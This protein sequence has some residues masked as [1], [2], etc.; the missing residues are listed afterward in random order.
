MPRAGAHVIAGALVDAALEWD[1][2][3]REVVTL[4]GDRIVFRSAGEGPVLLLVHG[5]AGS[6]ATWKHVFGRLAHRFTVVAPDL[7]G[8]GESD[9]P[10]SEYSLG[11]YAN[12]LRDLLDALGH[13]RA[14]VIGQ[15]F[16]GGVALQ[17]AYQFPERCERLVL[18]AS[19]GMGPDVNLLLRLLTLPG[20]ETVLAVG[21]APPV[22]AA[23]S[24]IGGWLARMGARRTPVGDE[25]WRSY[26]T[27]STGAA[28]RCR[29][30]STSRR[31][32]GCRC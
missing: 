19:G 3:A 29:R 7:L 20:A 24:R 26:A 4:D 23:A 13:A 10:H 11:T 17:L 22:R 15:S 16:G 21:A 32:S 12:T 1:R 31:T 8:Q 2:I 6:S 25:I 28:R 14:T 27:S 9:R 30:C 18:V 5:L